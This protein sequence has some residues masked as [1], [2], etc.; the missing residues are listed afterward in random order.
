MSLGAMLVQRLVAR[1]AWPRQIF[2]VKFHVLT[3]LPLLTLK[4]HK[5]KLKAKSV[6]N[7]ESTSINKARRINYPYIQDTLRASLTVTM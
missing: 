4:K 5:N 7:K 6:E 3:L 1:P 2:G